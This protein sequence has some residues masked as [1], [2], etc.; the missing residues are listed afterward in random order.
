[1]LGHPVRRQAGLGS[2]PA[3]GMGLAPSAGGEFPREDSFH[4]LHASEKLKL[5]TCTSAV[6]RE[7]ERNLGMCSPEELGPL[8]G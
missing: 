7:R 6:V 4:S 1:M 8:G 2:M 3:A 5:G